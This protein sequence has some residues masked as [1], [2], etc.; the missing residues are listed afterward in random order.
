MRSIWLK[1]KKIVVNNKRL[2]SHAEPVACCSCPDSV[3][4]KPDLTALPTFIGFDS[5]SARF[6]ITVW[7][8]RFG[9]SMFCTIYPLSVESFHHQVQW[10]S[11]VFSCSKSTQCC[12]ASLQA[13]A[14][15]V[16]P[17]LNIPLIAVCHRFCRCRT[18]TFTS[19]HSPLSTI[20]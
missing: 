19:L 10:Q 13:V 17:A 3:E 7:I 12:W 2:S 18:S 11:L 5:M 15:I 14:A 20:Q 9:G 4:L 8:V 16:T 6:S 1:K